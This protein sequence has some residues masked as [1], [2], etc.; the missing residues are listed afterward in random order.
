MNIVEYKKAIQFPLRQ[1]TLC[2]L[3]RDDE[4]LLAMK[5]RGFG[6]D[7]WNGVGGKPD[8]E[9]T[10]LETAIRETQEEIEVT[11]NDMEVVAI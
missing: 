10:I 5:K 9:E 3:I 4:I 2:F 8:G 7:R 6:K 11:P 1:S